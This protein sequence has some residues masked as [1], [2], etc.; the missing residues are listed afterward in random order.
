MKRLKRFRGFFSLC[1][2]AALL[3]ACGTTGD[4]EDGAPAPGDL[5]GPVGPVDPVEEL[6]RLEGLYKDAIRV[7]ITPQIVKQIRDEK[8]EQL[9]EEIRYY[10]SVNIV[11]VHDRAGSS[12]LGL[13]TQELRRPQG[14]EAAPEIEELTI[15]TFQE[16]GSTLNQS[17]ISRNDGGQLAGISPEGDVFEIHY[18]DRRITLGFVLNPERNWYDLAFAIEET[19]E[20]RVP[21]ALTGARPHLLIH[22]RTVFPSA[23]ETRI[24]LNAEPAPA[25]SLLTEQDS[26]PARLPPPPAAAPEALSP[27]VAEAPAAAAPPLEMASPAGAGAAAEALAEAGTAP[28]TGAEAAAAIAAENGAVPPQE[29]PLQ[30]SP[31]QESPAIAEAPPVRNP[32]AAGI[33]AAPAAAAPAVAAPPPPAQ[34]AGRAEPEAEAPRISA[35]SPPELSAPAK[36]AAPPQSPPIP[37][38]E[39]PP[40]RDPAEAEAY[41]LEY[42]IEVLLIMGGTAPSLPPAPLAVSSGVRDRAPGNYYTVQ[43]GAFQDEKNA[44]RAYAALER[45]GFSP[46]Y[47][48]RQNL[49]RVVIPD[50]EQKDLARTRERIKALGFGEPYLRR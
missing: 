7:P 46:L 16:G 27:A 34:S 23:G 38:A 48:S 6:E 2:M 19:G 4:L 39:L 45:G 10:P 15:L 26:A 44:A 42:D 17:R 22:Y 14:D 20:G 33:P 9:L 3:S 47:E 28:S 43:V 1:V 24:Q 8:K 41:A 25:T 49:T 37:V 21:L 36:P 30:E 29:P 40:L 35:N 18:P 32:P 11:L 50:V 12:S 13:E 31:L 5:A